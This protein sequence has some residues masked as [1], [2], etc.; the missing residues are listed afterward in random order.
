ME[1]EDITVY[2][3]KSWKRDL[4]YSCSEVMEAKDVFVY[5]WKL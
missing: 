1:V 3:V 4:Y 2:G 5:V